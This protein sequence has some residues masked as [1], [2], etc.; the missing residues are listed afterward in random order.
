MRYFKSKHFH[1]TWILA[2]LAAGAAVFYIERRYQLT[3]EDF[4]INPNHTF[5]EPEPKKMKP[6]TENEPPST[7]YELPDTLLLPV[8]FTPQAPTANWDAL[9]NEACEEAS[10]IM[11]S[12]YFL[13]NKNAQLDPELVEGQISK[14]T[15]W[16]TD[17]FGY[18]LDINSEE[19]ARL[20][21]EFYGLK[22]KILNDFTQTDIKN[23]LAQNHL[24]LLP[25]NGKLLGNPNFRSPGPPYHMLVIKGYN[26]LGFI[27]NDPGTKKGLN[28]PYSFQSLYKANGDFDHVKHAVD[29]TKKTAIV[30]WK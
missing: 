7:S 17:T 16:E 6:T 9:H 29:L 14:L 21:K 13:G 26:S 18:Y 8:P 20:L 4:P 5:T 19:T 30:V 25:S 23:E 22:A 12:E 27:T 11:V 28:Y 2:I 24:L 15:E 3:V 10:A 1:F